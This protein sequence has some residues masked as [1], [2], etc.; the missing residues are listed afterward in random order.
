MTDYKKQYLKYKKKYLKIKKMLGGSNPRDENLEDSNPLYRN[1]K[2]SEQ[3]IM[4]NLDFL[5]ETV[6]S[7]I[8]ERVE[9]EQTEQT[10]EKFRMLEENG[11]RIIEGETPEV[12]NKLPVFEIGKGIAS[13][14]VII[15][16]LFIL[17]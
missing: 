1:F 16:I 8:K 13:L 14:V 3:N 2:A 12:E 5:Q 9:E 10:E 7:K 15:G 6:F 17:K 4:A 11:I